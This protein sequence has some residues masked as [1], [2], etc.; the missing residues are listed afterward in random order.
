[1]QSGY[2]RPGAARGPW[3]A[4]IYYRVIN[5]STGPYGTES[6]V[7]SLRE[8]I[9]FFFRPWDPKHGIPC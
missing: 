8:E 6:E 3:A 7:Y 1:L 5:L 4:A 9:F 2:R